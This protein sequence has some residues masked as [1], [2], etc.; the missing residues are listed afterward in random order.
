[1]LY[2]AIKCLRVI[3]TH[4]FSKRYSKGIRFKLASYEP[5][6]LILDH[7]ST[8]VMHLGDLLFFLDII[9]LAHS[10]GMPVYLV[11]VSHLKGFFSL[12]NV[13]YE[14]NLLN[15][16]PG[17]VLTKNDSYL[18]FKKLDHTLIGFNFWQVKG[19][20]P[21]STILNHHF[22]EFCKMYFPN[23]CFEK[24]TKPFSDFLKS[25]PLK[26]VVFIIMKNG[27]LLIHLLT[28]NE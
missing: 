20:G 14:A 16:P 13:K 8:S 1:M 21:I 27:L 26:T 25:L 22:L 19:D 5:R 2:Y 11:G 28:L 12:F 10:N 4:L 23:L 17:I 9:W 6:A 18:F 7:T 15:V 24:P 3:G